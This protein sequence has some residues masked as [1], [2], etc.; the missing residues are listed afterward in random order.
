MNYKSLPHVMIYNTRVTSRNDFITS[1]NEK[2]LVSR[3]LFIWRY[4]KNNNFF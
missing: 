3:L 1:R 4:K 2:L